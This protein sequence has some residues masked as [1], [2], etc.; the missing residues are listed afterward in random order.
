MATLL[1]VVGSLRRDS[2]N[3]QLARRIAEILSG[4][5]R[6]EFLAFADMPHMNQ[7]IEFPAPEPVARVRKQVA[8]ADGLWFV[9]PEYNHGIPGPL[10]NLLDWLS[11]PMEPGGSSVLA[12]RIATFCGA[13]GVSS[14]ACVQDQML[15][16]L[17]FLRMRV[18][19]VPRALVSLTPGE[20]ASGRLQL[21][22]RAE[23]AVRAQAEAFVKML[24]GGGR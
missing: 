3:G 23:E 5:V 22:E 4:R 10:K 7:D 13:A 11:R 17:N 12:G 14:S 6:T 9:T 16:L 1:M 20:F 15:F 2:F 24:E 21:S 18:P 19:A 8:G